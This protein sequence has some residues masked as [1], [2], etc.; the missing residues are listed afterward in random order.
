MAE[1]AQLDWIEPLDQMSKGRARARDA[2][3]RYGIPE[4]A[5]HLHLDESTLRNQI[6]YRKRLDKAHSFWRPSQDCTLEL[7]FSDRRLREELLAL[8]E[9]RIEDIERQSPEDALRDI[10]A[11]A[12]SGEWGRAAREEITTLYRH[13]RKAPR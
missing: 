7:F 1:T 11:K 9:E 4:L 6:E 5:H 8:C 10:V 3:E 2:A 12:R 13:V